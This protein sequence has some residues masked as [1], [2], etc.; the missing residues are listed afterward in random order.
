MVTLVSQVGQATPMHAHQ[1]AHRLS[2][3]RIA[4]RAAGV[5]C[6]DIRCSVTSDATLHADPV[7]AAAV[8]G[9]P[10]RLLAVARMG[11][12]G[13]ELQISRSA[14]RRALAESGG[15]SLVCVALAELAA[16]FTISTLRYRLEWL[17]HVIAQPPFEG[18]LL[19]ALAALQPQQTLLA[20]WDVAGMVA[21][22]REDLTVSKESL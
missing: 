8:L 12:A 5:F 16:E 14:L 2:P 21:V 19:S 11:S 7:I 6:P 4:V 20:A 17:E 10:S 9:S 13:P 1:D 22:L 3:L 15:L 18:D